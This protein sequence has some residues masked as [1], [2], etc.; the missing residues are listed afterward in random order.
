[1]ATERRHMEND[2]LR[3]LIMAGQLMAEELRRLNGERPQSSKDTHLE[4]GLVDV[5]DV[6]LARFHSHHESM[7]RRLLDDSVTQTVVDA[8]RRTRQ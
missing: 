1:M 3:R 5:W 4:P 7:V 2:D 8:Q 6:C